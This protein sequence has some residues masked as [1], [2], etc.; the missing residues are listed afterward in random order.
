MI[1]FLSLLAAV[2]NTPCTGLIGCGQGAANVLLDNLPSVGTLMITIAAGSAVLFIAFA[3]LQ[4]VLA[5]GND[6]KVS[7]Q[8]TAILYVLIG[9]AIAI[10]SQVA[11][12]S[13]STDPGLDQITS[14]NLPLDILREALGLILL[15]FNACFTFAILVGGMKMVYAQ[16]KSDDFNAGRRIITWSIVGAVVI[17][18]AYAAVQALATIFGV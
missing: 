9:L 5:L 11:V 3:G 2:P 18:V 15:V 10:V 12:S 7:E 13:V 16:G 4:M 6:G 8:K 14:T 1:P 17:N